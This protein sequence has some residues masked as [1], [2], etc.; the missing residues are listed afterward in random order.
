MK[1][2]LYAFFIDGVT[3]LCYGSCLDYFTPGARILDVGIG[4]GIM[5]KE[6]HALI[7]EKGIRIVGVDLNEGYL[8]HCRE[9]IR[10]H[11]LT[12]RIQ[13]HHASV[14]KFQPGNGDFFD[15]ILFSMSFM[16]FRD[17]GMVLDRVRKWL[18]PEGKVVFFQTMFRERSLFMELVKPR[19]KYVTT[20][21]F[22]KVT[23]EDD[24][25][26]LLQGRDLSVLEDRLLKREWFRGEYR[27]IVAGRENGATASA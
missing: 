11:D 12:D 15:Y 7:R 10:A 23:Y 9:L 24:F 16:L 20:I 14:E 5:I 6:H 25:Y 1:N 21:D 27:L 17:Q 26:R 22:G 4:N 3:N 19:L 18:K 13:V 2:Q 8:A